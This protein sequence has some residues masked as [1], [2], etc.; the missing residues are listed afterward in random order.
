M[1]VWFNLNFSNNFSPSHDGNGNKLVQLAVHILERYLLFV[2]FRHYFSTDSS[3]SRAHKR[4]K[5]NLNVFENCIFV[6]FDRLHFH[7]DRT[8]KPC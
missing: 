4:I 5:V 6:T 3:L 7:G 8:L 2:L 1:W